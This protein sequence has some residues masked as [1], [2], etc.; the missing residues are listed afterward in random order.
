M[1]QEKRRRTDHRR[2]V[3]AVDDHLRPADHAVREG[4]AYEVAEVKVGC[5][6]PDEMYFLR[7][8]VERDGADE[9]V[10]EV[11]AEGVL[12]AGGEMSE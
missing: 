4:F 10:D 6:S 12:V 3:R 8:R 11:T 5:Y 1:H 9:L 2:I 7:L